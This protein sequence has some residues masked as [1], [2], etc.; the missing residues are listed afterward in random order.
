MLAVLGCRARLPAAAAVYVDLLRSLPLVLL[1]FWFAL[2]PIIV[3]HP[4]GGFYS[5]VIGFII[6]EEPISRDHPLGHRRCGAAVMAGLA[7]GLTRGACGCRVAAG[8]TRHGAGAS[9]NPSASSRARRWSMSSTCATSHRRRP[10]RRRDNRLTEMYVWSPVSWSADRLARRKPAAATKDRPVIPL[11][12]SAWYG[13]NHVP[14]TARSASERASRWCAPS[15]SGKSTLIKCING[16]GH[17]EEHH[18]RRGVRSAIRRP[19]CEA[20][21]ASA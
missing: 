3:G 1:I 7:G 10:H 13:S 4:V 16:P 15:G 21:R 17:S 6:F 14:T 20:A 11:S 9:C 8:V 5:A 18:Y 19:T 12:T 2:V